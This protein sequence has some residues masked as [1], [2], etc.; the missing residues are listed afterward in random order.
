MRLL[1]LREARVGSDDR[2]FCY[3]RTTAVLPILILLALAAGTAFYAIA[4]HWKPGYY[5]AGIV[6]LGCLLMRRFVTARFRT[7]NWLVRMNEAGLFIQ[8]RSYLIIIC[9][10]RI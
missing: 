9:R 6:A 10:L 2:V 4:V 8:F 7:S 3:S 5:I 1:R